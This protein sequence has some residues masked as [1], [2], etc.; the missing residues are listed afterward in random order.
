[1]GMELDSFEDGAELRAGPLRIFLDDGPRAS[2]VFELLTPNLDDAKGKLKFYGFEVISWYGVGRANIV[3]DP[4][5]LLFN[6]FEFDEDDSIDLQLGNHRIYRPIIGATSPAPK[7]ISEFY[8]MVLQQAANKLNDG[9]FLLSGG[10]VGFRVRPG[11]VD[12]QVL[13]MSHEAPV[14]HLIDSGCTPLEEDLSVITD[15]YG[16]C[17]AV[18]TRLQS[19]HAVVNPL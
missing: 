7:P 15:P 11:E 1:M 2:P 19:S 16:L 5:G 17:W 12:A 9:S 10:D 8:S 14:D 4:F 3:R 18:E 6:I 13:W